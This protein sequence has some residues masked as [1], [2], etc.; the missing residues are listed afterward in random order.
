MEAVRDAEVTTALLATRVVQ[1]AL[2]RARWRAS[3]PIEAFDRVVRERVLVA[4]ITQV[5]IT[6]EAGLVVYATEAG[7]VGQRVELSAEELDALRTG[8]AVARREDGTDPTRLGSGRAGQFVDVNV[9]L[10]APSGQPL[11]LQTRQPYE[12]V[13][14][15]SRAVWLTMLPSLMLALALLYLV[16][17]G[18]AFRLARDLLRCAGRT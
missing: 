2:P 16:K 9:G 11:L 12:V 17:A 15:T 10:R 5:L 7:L 6:D 14:L 4:P 13:W 8:V 3:T 1:P 18:F